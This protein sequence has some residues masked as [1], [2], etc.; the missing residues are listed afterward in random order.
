MIFS[1]QKPVADIN[2]ATDDEDGMLDSGWHLDKKVPITLI[3]SI[4][5]QTFVFGWYAGT[6][7]DRVARLEQTS[8]ATVAEFSKL[9]E[10]RE[11]TNLGLSQLQDSIS[12]M[13]DKLD[14]ILDVVK[15]QGN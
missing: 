1:F 10:A 4:I 13:R 11:K 14:A 12:A 5:V 3:G 8:P 2:G 9:E 15:R 7:N 6:L